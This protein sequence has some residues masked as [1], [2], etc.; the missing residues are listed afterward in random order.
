ME[1]NG[2]PQE[3]LKLIACITMLIDHIGAIFFPSL[4]I[5]RI[6]G[7]LSFPIYC[8]LLV[9]GAAHTRHAGK[10][11]L[12]LFI[13]ALISELP[14]DLAFGG[15]L[16]L[17]SLTVMASLLLGFGMLW[18]MG[19][20]T[21]WWMKAGIIG[22]S[23]VLARIFHVSYDWRGTLVIAVFALTREKPFAWLLQLVCL[24]VLFWGMPSAK[25]DLGFLLLPIQLFGLLAL[26]PIALYS[27]KKVTNSRAVQWGFYLFY[28]L[29][30][31]MLYLI[32]L[33]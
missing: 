10:Y 20:A 28:P 2:L 25:L 32:S 26:I 30:L 29:H 5:L 8:F 6:I 7:R 15:Q 23:M 18:A 3:G 12:R 16:S 1:R 17:K 24:S 13:C 27:G 9:E 21:K 33:I 19:K 11:A 22:I 31:L 4:R 14:Y